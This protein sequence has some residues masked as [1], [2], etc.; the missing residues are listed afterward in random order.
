MPNLCP[1]DSGQTFVNCCEPILTGK[2]DALTAQ[3][4][5]RSRY[6]AFTQANIDY[7]LRSHAAKTRP[8]KDR[9]NIERWARSVTWMGLSILRTE[10]GE[11]TDETGYV[12]FKA[13]YI[14]NGQPGQIHERSLFH[15]ENGQ[16]VYVS[17]VQF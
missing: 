7:L 4:L 3:Q 10:A 14:E 16:W 9:K 5:M 1:C 12:E 15:R 6:T 8:V 13:A 2:R 11:A 17:G